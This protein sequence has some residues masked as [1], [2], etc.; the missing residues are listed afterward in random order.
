MIVA[1]N[2]QAKWISNAVLIGVNNS[3]NVTSSVVVAVSASA[4][5]AVYS[6][7]KAQHAVIKVAACVQFN[8]VLS[9]YIYAVVPS[10]SSFS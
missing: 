10:S 3:P 4:Q 5:H 1:C 6:E 7:K 9:L 2:L 8:L